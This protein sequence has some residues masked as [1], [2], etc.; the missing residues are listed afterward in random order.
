MKKVIPIILALAMCLTLGACGKSNVSNTNY[1]PGNNDV[2]LQN[3]MP[4]NLPEGIF[5]EV[6][7]SDAEYAEEEFSFEEVRYI[8]YQYTSGVDIDFKF[9]NNTERRFDSVVFMAQ[10]LDERG[11]VVE[12]DILGADNIGAGQ[13]AWYKYQTNTT[14]AANSIEE[15]SK[16]IHSIMI[17]S[18]QVNVDS[19]KMMGIYDLQ[20]KDPI[21]V[22]VAEIQP[23]GEN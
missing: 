19:N 17:Y 23:K 20:F 7:L 18:V 8:T 16:T 2:N 9:R 15:V 6:E 22:P 13:G 11:D 4:K 21:I 12:D 3:P 5:D 1:L 14:L 10:G